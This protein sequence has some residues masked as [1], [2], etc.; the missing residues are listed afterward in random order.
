VPPTPL[1]RQH[2]Q[3]AAANPA[4]AAKTNGG[5][6]AIAATP[7]PAAFNAPG[8]VGA[9]GATM[10]PRVAAQTNPGQPNA[11]HAPT[12]G[13]QPAP[14][15]APP[16]PAGKAPPKQQQHAKPPKSERHEEGNR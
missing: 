1:Q 14:G 13:T 10:T 7:R 5:H 16:P 15:K 12:P 4:L 3:Q 9:R 8:V 11:A 2:V 6:P